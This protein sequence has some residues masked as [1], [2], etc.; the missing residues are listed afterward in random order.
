MSLAPVYPIQAIYQT[1]PERID[2]ITIFMKENKA[3][4]ATYDSSIDFD[5]YSVVNITKFNA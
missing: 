1:I 5:Y 3:R 4:C 2:A